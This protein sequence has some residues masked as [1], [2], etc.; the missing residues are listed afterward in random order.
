MDFN[1]YNRKKFTD[2]QLHILEEF[3]KKI[4]IYPDK[5]QLTALCETVAD[6]YQRV[7]YWFAAERKRSKRK[8]PDL[9]SGRQTR[10]SFSKEQR[11]V[12]KQFFVETSRYPTASQIQYLSDK[13]GDSEAR[14][15]Q[16]FLYTREQVKKKGYLVQEEGKKEE[17]ESSGD[18]AQTS[19]FSG[20][21]QTSGKLNVLQIESDDD[22][23]DEH[24]KT[25][26]RVVETAKLE[27]AS[28]VP[29][30]E[31]LIPESKIAE[32]LNSLNPKK[33]SETPN[34]TLDKKLPSL[35]INLN[36]STIQNKTQTNSPSPTASIVKSVS[37]KLSLQLSSTSKP[38]KTSVTLVFGESTDIKLLTK[39]RVDYVRDELLNGESKV[40]S[41]SAFSGKNLT[42]VKNLNLGS[43]DPD[44][45]QNVIFDFSKFGFTNKFP[46][47]K[48]TKTVDEISNV[49]P[50]SGNYLTRIGSFYGVCGASTRLLRD[51]LKDL[52][53]TFKNVNNVIGVVDN[54]A[55][56]SYK[57]IMVFL[58]QDSSLDFT[59]LEQNKT[60][61]NNL[62]CK[63][64]WFIEMV[65][66]AAIR[67][68]AQT[69]IKTMASEL[70]T[71]NN[72]DD[73]NDDVH[74]TDN[75]VANFSSD[76]EK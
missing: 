76:E 21:F 52:R 62:D 14:T 1:T 12:L 67:V 35:V 41:T 28:F 63:N 69:L 40:R 13:I 33:P 7:Q 51:W 2:Q 68:Q 59:L 74:K 6:D 72:F 54:E 44:S 31:A 66:N 19:S 70:Q 60:D 27:K 36:T 20:S 71:V 56:I 38:E 34:E 8:N 24:V 42:N 29:A 11:R 37:S 3:F 30:T 75:C 9:V 10:R 18:Q 55:E 25:P 16:W 49:E 17:G 43:I 46:F 58:S 64:P 39:E 4:T 50:D 53:S 5:Q 15:R 32:F 47:L 61:I 22:F 73:V 48:N 45:V 65:H 23:M 26:E 57:M